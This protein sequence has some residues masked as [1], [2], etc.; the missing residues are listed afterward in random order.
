MD[1]GETFTPTF[2]EEGKLDGCWYWGKLNPCMKYQYFLKFIEL[3]DKITIPKWQKWLMKI[4]P[5][6]YPAVYEPTVKPITARWWLQIKEWWTLLT[7]PVYRDL[8]N[9]EMWS[10]HE[11]VKEIESKYSD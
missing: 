8:A 9:S 4:I 6:Y 2:N 7:D 1:C 3:N 10:C 5:D 11:C